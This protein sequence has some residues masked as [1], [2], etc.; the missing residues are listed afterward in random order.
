M[1]RACAR[2]VE[3][4]ADEQDLKQS[5]GPAGATTAGADEADAAGGGDDTKWL[6]I[7]EE[8]ADEVLELSALPA[9]LRL[10]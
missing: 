4:D 1:L 9:L 5:S 7:V 6:S 3:T 10:A 2:F 8:H